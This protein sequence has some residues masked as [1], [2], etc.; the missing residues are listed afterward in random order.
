VQARV[1][2]AEVMRNL[3]D[4]RDVHLV[5]DVLRVLAGSQRGAHEDRDAV[6]QHAAVPLP[7]LR[8]GHAVVHTEQVRVLLRRLVLDKDH[9]IAHE[10][11]EL[12]RDGVEGVGDQA[13]ELAA[14][15]IQHGSPRYGSPGGR[16]THNEATVFSLPS[17]RRLL[18]STGA[19][20]LRY[21]AFI[22]VAVIGA[23]IG[24]LLGAHVNEQVGPFHT[25]LSLAPSWT[26]DTRVEIPPLGSLT[27]DSH[28]GPLQLRIDVVEIDSDAAREIVNNPMSLRGVGASVTTE[29][30]DGVAVLLVRGIGAAVVGAA[31]LTLLVW[32]V[33]SRALLA[34]GLVALTFL[35]ASGVAVLSLDRRSVAEPR[36]EG[37]LVSAPAVVGSA[38]SVVSDFAQYEA[39]LAQIVTNVTE[40]YQA[41]SSLPTFTPDDSTV[42]VLHV[43][44]LHLNPSAWGVIHSV[45]RQY[46]ID[47]VVD[48]GDFTDRGLAIEGEQYARQ[49]PTLGVP[50]V[51]IRGNHDSA[52]VQAA[53]AAQ[54]NAVVLD[55]GSTAEVAGLRF[56]G[57][58]DPRFTPDRSEGRRDDELLERESDALV[59][60]VRG[61]E[62]APD[63]ALVH[64]PTLATDLDGL[65]PL[66][67]AGHVHE[68]SV[69][70]LDSGTQVMVQGSTGGAGLR[71]LEGEEPTD[72]QMSVLYVDRST[73][74]LEAWDEITLG[75]IGLTS[76]EIVR[77]IAPA[78][79]DSDADLPPDES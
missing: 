23:W 45:V 58:G 48:T 43:S 57:T 41:A 22:V 33:R 20:I 8:Q 50:Y 37:L 61:Q 70:E 6:G 15:H 36:F 56:V 53:V 52:A 68:R 16:N 1:V 34:S 38:R 67:L 54:P 62:S 28:D 49:I 26:G 42:R 39:E 9:D 59:R 4:N 71:G 21:T 74:Q 72:L 65:V 79:P 13:L 18:T 25:H 19:P 40:L 51:W 30:R 3:V 69:R 5:H 27:V 24:L 47:V 2:D 77:R 55:D 78:E 63:I 32:R 29:L 75:G 44:D 17:L 11:G 12:G 31:V 73:R 66:V 10:G 46:A 60:A 76:A 7:S 35:L 64:D 14:A